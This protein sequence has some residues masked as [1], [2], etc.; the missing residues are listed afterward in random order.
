MYIGDTCAH[1]HV[2]VSVS[3]T[4]FMRVKVIVGY[5]E[6]TKFFTFFI[7]E[8][9]IA[10]LN[11]SC[12]VFLFSH[13]HNLNWLPSYRMYPF[14]SAFSKNKINSL[15]LIYFLSSLFM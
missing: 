11:H 5:V 2:C 10:S 13:I 12:K 8:Y 14:C 1:T 3:H 15:F 9:F 4:L 7:Y 6:N